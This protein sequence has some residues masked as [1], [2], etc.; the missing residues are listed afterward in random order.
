MLNTGRTTLIILYSDKSE[1]GFDRILLPTHEI[2]NVCSQFYGKM[3]NFIP[4]TWKCVPWIAHFHRRH[5][6]VSNKAPFFKS[7]TFPVI[8]FNR[9]F[10]LFWFQKAVR[11]RFE[12]R[13]IAS[14]EVFAIVWWSFCRWSGGRWITSSSLQRR[15]KSCSIDYKTFHRKHVFACL[16]TIDSQTII[17]F[18]SF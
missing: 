3:F 6:S 1:H 7:L 18:G 5:P 16:S 11:F 17:L 12:E 15:C 10:D 8:F 4:W 2:G 13:I 14:F 9:I